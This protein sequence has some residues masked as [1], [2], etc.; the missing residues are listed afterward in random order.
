VVLDRSVIAQGRSLDIEVEV[1]NR[2]P[3]A[4]LVTLTFSV[5][6]PGSGLPPV[7][8]ERWISS[9]GGHRSQV[10]RT[11]VTPSQWFEGL[12]RFR[13]LVTSEGARGDARGFRVR[14]PPVR[15]PRFED[16]TGAVG[17]GTTHRATDN[18]E[19]YAAGAAW[20]DVEGDGDL[21]LYLP[22]QEGPSALF[23]NDGGI[24]SEQAV[25]RGVDN[26][27]SVGIG[28]TFA[29]YDND[30]DSDL[31]VV[32]HGDDRLFQNDG[33][34][35]FADVTASA[36]VGEP[37]PGSSAAWGDYD[38]DGNLDLY[39]TNW[40]EEAVA[41][42]SLTYAED[43]LYHNEG[44]GTFTDAT[45]LLEASGSTLGAGFQAAWFDYDSDG[46]DDLYLGNDFLGQSP[47]PNVLWRNDGP[48][49]SGGWR[50]TNVSN[51]SRAGVSINTM[52]LA[53]G[54]F[55]RDG[56]L[57]LGLS[58]LFET[59]LLRNDGAG[60]F[61]DV[62]ERMGVSRPEQRVDEMS[63]TW[64]MGFF[65]F[66]NDGREDLHVV[67]GSLGQEGDVEA[68]PDAMFANAPRGFLD[69]SAPSHADDDG[70][71][72]GAAYADFDRDGRMDIYLVNRDGTPRLFRNVTR[73]KK[74]HWLQVDLT[75]TTSNR[76]GCG[77]MLTAR[78]SGNVKLVRELFCSSV[79]LA[80]GNEPV[81]HFGLGEQRKV[82]RLTI[83]WPSG[84]VQV[85][86]KVAG[87][88]RLAVVEP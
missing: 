28:A 52:G 70:V 20:G 50:F 80:S 88:R 65:D 60:G 4:E 51:E 25:A 30:G 22:Y 15:A 6:K 7:T 3:A 59:F 5:S 32:N 44:D 62:A 48:D 76:D 16:V 37:G 19:N 43:T 38:R 71:G 61:T 17:L 57:D 12:G 79:S 29:D 49:G 42:R 86:T 82:K 54:D 10:V 87:D 9:V 58:N 13:I 69:L 72:R 53:P 78:L 31:F 85:L 40:G 11:S 45:H 24:F 68:Q 35:Q 74:A 64:G 77:A 55:D 67:G 18:C 14:R 56:D 34:G 75:G 73:T 2:G 36:G 63:V 21:D 27:G 23:V 83:R 46:D 39:V 8:F 1:V 41:C 66:N 84:K 47:R 26:L 81:A 33:A